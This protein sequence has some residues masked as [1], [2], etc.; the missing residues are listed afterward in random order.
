[1]PRIGE[2]V[3]SF[4]GAYPQGL[5]QRMASGA[6]AAKHGSIGSISVSSCIRSFKEIGM[7]P[8]FVESIS[9]VPAE[10]F[11]RRKWH[12][13]PEWI[14][15]LCNSLSFKECFRYKYK[16]SR[17]GH[18]NVNEGRTYKSW[19][20]M[21]AKERPNCRFLGIL[22]SRVTIGAAAKGHSSSDSLSRI[23]R[24][25]LPYIVGAN[26]YPGCVH[27]SSQ[28]NRADEP[29]R[30]RAVRGPSREKPRWLIELQ[31]DR[32]RHFDVV[33]SASHATRVVG[34]WIRLLL[35]IAGDIEQNPGP[36]VK[37][38]TP[39]RQP[40]LQPQPKGWKSVMMLL[41]F[42]YLMNFHDLFGS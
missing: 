33:L 8:S 34:R 23:F 10:P 3:A 41:S 22:D 24:G 25:C 27:C 38:Q 35:L 18:I 5:V 29:S 28:D 26:L 17:S 11:P 1:M 39:L 36:R 21:M 12:E 9:S 19:I 2:S 30:D 4:S 37:Q 6:V 16:F 7:D 13:D 14:S 31:Q 15:E 40:L 32:T 42:G 20:K